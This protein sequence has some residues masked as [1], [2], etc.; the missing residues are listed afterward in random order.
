MFWFDPEEVVWVV[1]AFD[2]HEAVAATAAAGAH[3]TLVVGVVVLDPGVVG[4]VLTGSGHI[5]RWDVVG[6]ASRPTRDRAVR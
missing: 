1:L 5:P 2:L 6:V 3:P 4:L